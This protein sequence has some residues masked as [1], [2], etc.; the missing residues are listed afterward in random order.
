[1]KTLLLAGLLLFAMTLTARAD[2]APVGCGSFGLSTGAC[3]TFTVAGTAA[4]NLP[5]TF[6]LTGFDLSTGLYFFS[7]PVFALN[8]DSL[9]SWM[10]DIFPLTNRIDLSLAGS[11]LSPIDLFS[12][13]ALLTGP[14]TAESWTLGNHSIGNGLSFTVTTMPEPGALEMLLFGLPLLG[15]ARKLW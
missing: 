1:M 2:S 15:I 7:V 13:T 3:D 6:D 8:G 4:F 5:A 9:G 11:P 12:S 14:V 10:V